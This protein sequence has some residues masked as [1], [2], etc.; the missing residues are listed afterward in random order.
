MNELI[1]LPGPTPVTPES[2]QAQ[3]KQIIGHRV[4][5]FSELLTRVTNNLKKVFMTKNDVL[6]FPASG[7]GGL[8][9]A[10]VNCLSVGDKILSIGNG[11]FAERFREIAKINNIEV[12]SLD[13][14]R[15]KSCNYNKIKDCLSSNPDLKAVLFTHNET[16][17]GVQNNVKKIGEFLKN[18]SAL[19]LVDAVSSLGGIP[20]KTDE[21]GADVVITSSQKALMTPPGL[22]ILS[23]SKN[24]W[25]EIE[26]SS[27]PKFYWDLTKAKNYYNNRKQTPYTPA[28]SL[29]YALDKALINIL[30]EGLNNVFKRHK[31]LT[32]SFRKG[33]KELGFKPFVPWSIASYTVSAFKQREDI[34]FNKFK[35]HLLNNYKLYFTG[36]QQDLKNDIFRVGH[37]GYINP[38]NILQAVERFGCTLQDFN[39]QCNI[40]SAIAT[41]SDII[42]GGNL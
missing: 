10:I 30:N 19:L 27:T 18:H 25:N 8:E 23:V 31:V 29:I 34:E 39:I 9:I 1:M 14:P 20:L 21:W 36:G 5:A 11:V 2:L 22:A 4:K 35:K 13:F 17:T 41:T 6:I 26:K 28:V 37:M 7:T 3:S 32:R 15:G 12:I 16:S 38:D 33:M 24:A 40:D 42:K